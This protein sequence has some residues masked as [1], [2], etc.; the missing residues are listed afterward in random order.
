MMHHHLQLDGLH[1]TLLTRFLCV[2]SNLEH[3]LTKWCFDEC[4]PDEPA[5]THHL[6][7]RLQNLEIQFSHLGFFL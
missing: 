2:T 5:M 6:G 3:L 7:R 1:T 4:I